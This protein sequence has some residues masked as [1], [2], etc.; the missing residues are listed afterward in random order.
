MNKDAHSIYETYKT[1]SANKE[2]L[3]EGLFDRLKARGAQAVGSIKGV[4]Q[5]A[6]GGAQKLAGKAAGAAGSLG[7]ALGSK[8]A[9]N[10][11]KQVGSEIQSAAQKKITSGKGSAELA[12]YQS[13]IKSTVAN[14]VNDLKKLNI[15]VKNEAALQAALTA[16]ILGQLQQVTKGGQLRGA[17]GKIGG[18]VA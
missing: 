11:G 12:K 17:S 18:K 15:P 1:T 6:M 4:G 5:Q 13:I 2:I 14:T 8:T 16:A 10:L 3:E 9:A 7:G